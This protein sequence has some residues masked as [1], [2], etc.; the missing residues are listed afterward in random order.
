MESTSTL[1][2][3]NHCF[4]SYESSFCT[5]IA[6]A[7]S[8]FLGLEFRVRLVSASYEPT[9]ILKDSDY[10]VTQVNFTEE[11]FLKM[12]ISDIATNLMFLESLG[13]RQQ[14]PGFLRLKDL[15]GLEASV[16]AGYCEFL[17]NELKELFLDRKEINSV[18]HTLDNEKTLYLTFY[19]SGNSEY[20]A[21]RIILA[22]PHF[23]L[24]K[25]NPV[26]LTTTPI[27]Y[28]FF[29]ESKVD[30]NILIGKTRAPLEDIKGLEPEDIIILDDSDLYRMYLS[31]YENIAINV[32]PSHSLVLDLE[33][34][35]GVDNIVNDV[36]ENKVN[37]WDTLEVDVIAS[38]EKVKI[39]LGDLRNI[40]EGLV[41][42]VASISDNKVYVEVENRQLASGELVIVGD[43][44]GIRI[45]E[46]CSDA[47]SREV[48]KLEQGVARGMGQPEHYQ[49][50]AEVT[51]SDYESDEEEEVD[52]SDFEMDEEDEDDEDDDDEDDDDEDDEE[53]N[54][55]DEKDNDDD[56]EEEEED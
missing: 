6:K 47:K 56:D 14:E 17:Y 44:Y 43:K 34:E 13:K 24:R 33:E 3:L 48:E 9:F 54:N 23:V 52:D 26:S 10:F 7:S 4:Q 15:T 1:M 12:K 18:L 40:T 20:E 21:G 8:E 49:E 37:I 41:I 30:T 25:T 53:D 46:I 11:Y 2:S 19:I 27:K 51:E 36:K 29:D 55:D 31:E 45:T 16:L 22:F 5:A 35:N 50:D 32:N 28:K 39:K 38:F 42:D